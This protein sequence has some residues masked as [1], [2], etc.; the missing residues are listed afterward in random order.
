MEILLQIFCGLVGLIMGGAILIV[1]FILVWML[2][3]ALVEWWEWFYNKWIALVDDYRWTWKW[4]IGMNWNGM[5]DVPTVNAPKQVGSKTQYYGQ[6]ADAKEKLDNLTKELTKANYCKYQL[7]N[8]MMSDEVYKRKL[9]AVERIEN[10]YP[11]MAR[12]CSP[13]KMRCYS[14][15][16]AL[17]VYGSVDWYI[18]KRTLELTKP[19]VTLK[20]KFAKD[21]DP[22]DLYEGPYGG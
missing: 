17:E 21:E 13:V 20:K 6:K 3:V 8:P 16:A 2:C 19:D 18:L 11:E 5:W 22:L 10:L 4:D 15:A 12:W 1:I 9:E 7:R 14:E